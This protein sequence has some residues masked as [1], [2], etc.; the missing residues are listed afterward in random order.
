MKIVVPLLI[1][2][3]VLIRFYNLNWGGPFYFHPDERNIA[4]SVTQ[5][6]FPTQM[7]PHFFAYGSFPIYVIYFSSFFINLFSKSQFDFSQAII[8]SRFYSALFSFLLIPSLYFIGNKIG[9]EKTGILAS[10]FALFS[11]G[12]IQFAHFGTFEMWLTFLGIWLFYFS[13]N[14]IGKLS[15]KNIV[16]CAALSG[17]LVSTKIS[18]L[19]I[20]AI[21]IF[22]IFLNLSSRIKTKKL[23]FKFQTLSLIVLKTLLMFCVSLIIFAATSPFVFLD[24]PSF[25]SSIKYESSVAF[26]IL[27]VFYTGEFFNSIP[28]I[29]QFTKIY[30]FILN[31]ILTILFIPSFLYILFKA[32]KPKYLAY[33]LL[34]TC[35]LLLFIPQAFLFAKWTRYIIPTLP[36]VYLIIAIGFSNFLKY[37]YTGILAVAISFLFSISYFITAFVSSDTRVSAVNFASKIIPSNVKIISEVYDLGIIPFNSS[38]SNITLFNFYDLDQ[39]SNPS[40]ELE[41]LLQNSEFIVLPSQRILKTRLINKDNFPNGNKFYRNLLSGKLGFKKI[42]E[43]SCD[44]FCKITYLGDPVFSLEQT[45]N[46]F[47][48]PTLF[49]FE[50]IKRISNF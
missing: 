31:P 42:Y 20:L 32:I 2:F 28:I 37:R 40:F 23:I 50:K 8:I 6:N 45:A 1:F 36:F 4:S 21:P 26:G 15:L 25:A 35:Y 39:T 9:G 46:V 10:L 17:V 14:L 5:L 29:F 34:S 48:R 27:S 11:V 49:I 33:L 24:F 19:P 47:D 38:F 3:G 13:L 18:S 12:L 16:I 7:N 41:N 22:S 44:I 43:T 30:P